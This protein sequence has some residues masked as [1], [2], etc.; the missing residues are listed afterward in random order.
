M[1][2]T[3]SKCKKVYRIDPNRIPNAVSCTRCKVCGHAI[4]LKP[5]SDAPPLKPLPEK[6]AGQ[7]ADTRQITCLYCGKKYSIKASRIPPGVN[8]TKCKACGRNL[9]LLPAA[10]LTFSFKE[11]IL[12]KKTVSKS[13]KAA[14]DQRVPQVPIIQTIDPPTAPVWRKPWALA[15]AAALMVLFIG[16]YYTG[17][18]LTQ[19]ANVKLSAENATGT[20]RQAPLQKGQDD[21]VAAPEPILAAKFDVPLLLEVIDQNIAEEKK[22]FKYKTAAAI[23]RSFGL[24][25]VQLYL[26]P[27]PEH[28]FL[29]VILAAGNQNQNLEKQLKSKGNYVRLLKHLPDGSYAI[30]KEALPEDQQKKFPIDLYRLQFVNNT[31]VFAPQQLSRIFKEGKDPLRQS[32][33]AQMIASISGPRDLALLSLRIPEN[34]RP[35]LQKKIQSNPALQQNPQAV[36]AAAMGGGAIARLSELL[37]DAEFLA[38]GFRLEDSN[39]RQLSYVQ[40]FRKEAQGRKIYQQLKSG[41]RDDL[42]VNGIASKLIDLLSDPNYNHNILYEHN[43]LTLE[44]GWEKQHDKKLL[45]AL[46]EATL[47]Q[48]FTQ[49]MGLTPSQGP[50]TG[51]PEN[52]KSQQYKDQASLPGAGRSK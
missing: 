1:Q 32:R 27:H 12:K 4:S 6:T 49:E 42:E 7:D 40:Q 52:P 3:C 50:I 19:V 15:A 8:T 35:D 30:K 45:T 24:S 5:R 17:S 29:P 36:M 41:K 9:S 31:A 43:R 20:A 44:L 14:K 26:Y 11:E 2:I 16:V 47:G 46:S 25:K 22:N 34:F 21:P 33:L 18:K 13:S 23:V 38:I 10:G 48:M 39:R 51:Q 28:T 37:K